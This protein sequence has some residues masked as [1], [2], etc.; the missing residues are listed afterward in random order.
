MRSYPANS[1]DILQASAPQDPDSELFYG[2][3]YKP[4]VWEPGVVYNKLL[5]WVAPTVPNGYLYIITSNGVSGLDEPVWPTVAKGTIDDG[6]VKFK[7]IEYN[8]FLFPGDTLTDSAWTATGGVP[9]TNTSFTAEGETLAMFGTIPAGVTEFT[10][11]NSV[12]KHNGEKDDRS[13]LITVA[14]R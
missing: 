2:F 10:I 5:N 7:A 12:T 4:Q 8:A 11:T 6:T 1:Q 13:L 14:E 3:K 9:V